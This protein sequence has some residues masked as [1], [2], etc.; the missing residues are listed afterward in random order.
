MTESQFTC[1]LLTALRS[2]LPEAHIIKFNDRTTGGIP[3]FCIVHNG[4]THWFEVKVN[5]RNP[6][7]PLQ[8]ETL[9]RM[10]GHY[11]IVT[12]GEHFLFRVVTPYGMHAL[13]PCGVA[14]SYDE[15]KMG[16]LRLVR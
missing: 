16:I 9:R 10:H 6:C 5:N 14:M 1:K 4:V 2:Q 15:L 13:S 7:E 12:N 8:W 11:I 3:D